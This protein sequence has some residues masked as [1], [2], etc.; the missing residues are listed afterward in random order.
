MHLGPAGAARSKDPPT[1]KVYS[2]FAAFIMNIFVVTFQVHKKK[3]SG[4]H[5]TLTHT[6]TLSHSDS[7]QHEL[8]HE[9]LVDG[10]DKARRDRLDMHRQTEPQKHIWDERPNADGRTTHDGPTR[11]TAMM[12]RA[13]TRDLNWAADTSPLIVQDSFA[14]C[15]TDWRRLPELQRV[16]ASWG[17]GE[18]LFRVSGCAG[19]FNRMGNEIGW[20]NGHTEFLQLKQTR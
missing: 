4:E 2:C 18:R 11:R 10:P 15:Q 13:K 20:G 9:N 1:E 16:L 8:A 5:D 6:H 19:L 7:S 14:N 12:S 3:T 17:A